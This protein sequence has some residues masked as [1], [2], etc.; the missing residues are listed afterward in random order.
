MQYPKMPY[1]W[2]SDYDWNITVDGILDGIFMRYHMKQAR[3]CGESPPSPRWFICKN[4][5]NNIPK[6]RKALGM[7]VMSNGISKEKSCI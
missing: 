2:T 7:M 5:Q 1:E 4:C 3:S 6:H